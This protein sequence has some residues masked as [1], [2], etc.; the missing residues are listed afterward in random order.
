MK[1]E[2][3]NQRLANNKTKRPTRRQLLNINSLKD[4]TK[5]Q[6]RKQGIQKLEEKIRFN[7]KDIQLAIKKIDDL[8]FEYEDLKNE[9]NRRNLAK[10]YT[11]LLSLAIIR[12]EGST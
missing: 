3:L 11:N 2:S 6:E 1:V 12:I 4:E 7:E 8:S 10:F 9:M 5:K